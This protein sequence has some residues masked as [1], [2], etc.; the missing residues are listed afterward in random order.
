MRRST[1]GSQIP[2]R[3]SARHRRRGIATEAE[4]DVLV[5]PVAE[6]NEVPFTAAAKAHRED[7]AF[8][9]RAWAN[10]DVNFATIVAWSHWLRGIF[11]AAIDAGERQVEA[12]F[13]EAIH[14]ARQQK[15]ISLEKRAES[16]YAQYNK[17]KASSDLAGPAQCAEWDPGI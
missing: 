14:I 15:S 2:A 4:I 16:I 6:A 5:P 3:S 11:L 7:I 10:K 12:A 13:G 8:L 9:D 1:S 17:P